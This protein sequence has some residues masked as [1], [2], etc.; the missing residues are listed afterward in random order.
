MGALSWVTNDYKSEKK[1]NEKKT[2]E[3]GFYISQTCQTNKEKIS[4]KT[5]QITTDYK[6]R[7]IKIDKKNTMSLASTFRNGARQGKHDG[8]L[9]FADW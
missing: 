5:F 1:K 8:R 6:S 3:P 2:D 9:I 4:S 7:K